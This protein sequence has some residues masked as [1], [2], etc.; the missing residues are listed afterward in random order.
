MSDKN[1][2]QMV[3]AVNIPSDILDNIAKAREAKT[4]EERKAASR[5]FVDGLMNLHRRW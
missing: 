3:V 5:A 4:E 1:E 2:K